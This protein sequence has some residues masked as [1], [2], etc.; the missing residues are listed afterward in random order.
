MNS[1]ELPRP[2]RRVALEILVIA[3]ITL[4]LGEVVLRVYDRFSPSFVFE[5]ETYNRYRGR[6]GADYWGFP[7]NSQGFNDLESGPKSPATR[8]ILA[9][10]DSFAFGI[11]PYRHNYLTLVEERLKAAGMAVEV[12]NAGVPST[13]P[14]DY[15][16]LLVREGLAL[17]PDAVMLS[18]FAGND[19]E[20][21]E[22]RKLWQ[23][24]HVATVIRSIYRLVR[25]YEGPALSR[26]G[27][28]CDECPNYDPEFFLHLEMQRS[29]FFL[30][31]DQAIRAGVD[32]AL[33]VL[34]EIKRVCDERR[35]PLFIVIIPA[36]LQF[37]MALQKEVMARLPPGTKWDNTRP[38]RLLQERLDR[39]GV[40][41]LDLYPEFAEASKTTVLYRPR[42]TH[43]NI[44]GNR[45]AA[46]A[47]ARA[48]LARPEVAVR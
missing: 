24:S 8:R 30:E 1:P 19:F 7:L 27:Q 39:L 20:Q 11:V 31:N 40:P 22:Q 17:E 2:R 6:P 42:D 26:P 36:E 12:L 9:I 46:E 34:A 35:I 48:L 28:Y 44:A 15:L 45:L 33:A 43:W 10:G 5:Y 13:G 41:Y 29:K 18:F 21:D 38:N 32:N 25:Y 23:Y 47:I 14:R 4:V 16:A 37:N 3:L